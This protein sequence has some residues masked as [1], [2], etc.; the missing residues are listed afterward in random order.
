VADGLDRLGVPGRAELLRLH[1]L[2]LATCCAPEQ[3]PER[4]GWHARLVELLAHGV[5]PCVPHRTV[6]LGGGVDLTFHL[7][8]P[9]AF[10]M[11]S[12]PGEPGRRDDEARHRVTLTAARWLGTGPVTQAQWRAVL[13]RNPSR[14]PGDGH[15]VEGV[16]WHDGAAFCRKL[17]ARLGRPCRLPTEAE[18]E[19]ACRAGTTTPY[20][21][22]DAL[23]AG[24]ANCDG[25]HAAAGGGRGTCRDGTT[26]VE[27]F[28]PNA[29][30][31]FDLHGNVRE[32][33]SD[34]Y[35]AYPAGDE[36]DPQGPDEGPGRVLRGG[37]WC[38]GPGECRSASRGWLG[39]GDR[40]DD[41]GCRV[42][43]GPD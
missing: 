35:G 22:G 41:V 9:G 31:L 28:M 42:V 43:L 30:G 20:Q 1:R 17:G 33:C 15:P 6:P 12:P 16:S 38:R 14:F 2:L 18:W 26:P 25:G 7:V 34:W 4:R 32:W 11:G 36:A 19:Y 21:F 39:P 37:S 10:L 27:S 5:R 8:P 40:S 13:G 23:S 29:W 3:H 24:E